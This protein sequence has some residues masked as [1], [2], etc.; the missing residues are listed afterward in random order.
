[1][2]VESILMTPRIID[3][4]LFRRTL[5][6]F[7]A[8]L[9][10]LSALYVIIDLITDKLDNI[11]EN[12]VPWRTVGQFYI[13]FLP[14]ILVQSVPVA[15]LVSILFVLGEMVRYGELVALRAAGLSLQRITVGALLA[16][17]LVTLGTF[18]VYGWVVPLG[19][20]LANEIKENVID[21]ERAGRHHPIFYVDPESGKT[22]WISRYFPQSSRGENVIIVEYLSDQNLVVTQAEKIRWAPETSEWFLENAV[23][24]WAIGDEISYPDP[25]AEMAADIQTDPAQLEDPILP[26]DEMTHREISEE[27]HRRHNK[28]HRA[29]DLEVAQH[30]KFALPAVNLIVPFLAI[31]FAVRKRRGGL[32]LS[33]GMCIVLTLVYL[34][35]IAGSS[36]LG[37]FGLI[38]PWLGAWG[39]NA[40]F[41]AGGLWFFF[42]AHR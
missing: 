25:V 36:G 16:G 32:I 29:P 3:R 30:M 1:M 4:Y 35:L 38:P 6:I 42:R 18:I 33:F 8:A 21:P 13:C 7:L 41:L 39:P 19:S 40:L 2:E 24:C 14:R 23:Q 17:G 37:R 5:Q 28:G 22:I 31:P 34:G 10:V 27:I 9:L 15:L 11:K 26:A 20:S 12:D